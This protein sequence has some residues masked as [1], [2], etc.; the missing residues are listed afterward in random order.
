MWTDG[1]VLR[2][3][4]RDAKRVAKNA[5]RISK[6]LSKTVV[7]ALPLSSLLLPQKFSRAARG[8]FASVF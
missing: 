6:R 8:S 4:P 3:A 2:L 5:R 1:S 7:S